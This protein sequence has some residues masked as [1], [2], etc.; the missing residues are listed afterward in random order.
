MKNYIKPNIKIEIIEIDDVILVSKT[1][2]ALGW[3]N[4]GADEEL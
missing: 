2:T 1:D 3:E 4:V